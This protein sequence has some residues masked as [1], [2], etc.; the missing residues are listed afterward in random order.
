MRPL[1]AVRTGMSVFGTGKEKLA[2]P[3]AVPLLLAAVLS[4]AVCIFATPSFSQETGGAGGNGSIRDPLPAAPEGLRQTRMAAARPPPSIGGGG[5]GGVSPCHGVGRSRR[6]GWPYARRRWR[7]RGKLRSGHLLRVFGDRL[8]HAGRRRRSR[9]H[10]CTGGRWWWRWRRRRR[11]GLLTGT[12]SSV[13]GGNISGATGGAGGSG[14][15]GV[16]DSRG[17]G[18]GGGDGGVGATALTTAGG[19]LT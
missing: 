2:A 10:H 7:G 9:G 14:G 5:G 15:G 4:S 17:N 6:S 16:T 18:G 8:W 13:T 11:W 3:R 19:S 12:S 1:P